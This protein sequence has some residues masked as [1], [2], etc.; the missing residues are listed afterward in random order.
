MY[1]VFDTETT[2]LPKD[3]KAKMSDVDNWGRVIQ[4]AFS[5]Y[6]SQCQLV[7]E[8]CELI[9]PDGWV[10]PS[11]AGYM[12]EGMSLEEATK[13]AKFWVDNGFTTDQNALEGVPMHKALDMFITYYNM[14]KY[15]IAHNIEFDYN[16][17]G[18]EMLR[19]HKRA[20]HQLPRICTQAESTNFCAIPSPYKKFGFKFPGLMEVYT[21]LFSEG[22][23][24][25]HDAMADVRGCARVFFELINR[26]I[27]VLSKFQ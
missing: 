8:Y 7:F 14:C 6:D 23:G 12:G 2:G 27:I 20:A 5:V 3:K 11:V 17:V 24:N 9:V 18:A 22:F 1:L 19:Y 4:L 26:G 16:T 21:K 25:A 15:L 13:K 10:V